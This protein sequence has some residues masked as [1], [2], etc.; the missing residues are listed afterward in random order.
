MAL[1]IACN[2]TGGAYSGHARPEV[3]LVADL[4]ALM[5]IMMATSAELISADSILVK[6]HLYLRE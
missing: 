1:K 3:G 2:S 6:T 5:H 4:A